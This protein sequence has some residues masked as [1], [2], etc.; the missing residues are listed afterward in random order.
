VLHRTGLTLIPMVFLAA[1]AHAALSPLNE[2]IREIETI[3]DDA[4]LRDA[5]ANQEPIVS[6]TAPEQDVFEFKTLSCTIDVR[7]VDD[8]SKPP[9]I[10]GR[11]F[12]LEFGDV[13][14][15]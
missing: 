10:G 7:V 8:K 12:V 15:K 13:A 9:I 1:P 2:S 5:F 3:L 4:R 6:I 14:C 11:Q